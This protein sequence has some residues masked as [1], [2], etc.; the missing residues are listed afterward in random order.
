[1]K[2]CARQTS[3]PRVTSTVVNADLGQMEVATR[4]HTQSAVPATGASSADRI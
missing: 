4:H 1:M 3:A 2:R